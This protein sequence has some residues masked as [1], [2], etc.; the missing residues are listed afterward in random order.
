MTV[1]IV[2]VANQGSGGGTEPDELARRLEAHGA[3]VERFELESL[4]RIPSARPDRLVVA[5]GDGTVGP[6]AQ[7]ASKVGVPLAVIPTGTANDFARALE[8]PQDVDAACALA[9]RGARRQAI[10][11]ARLGERPFVNAAS[12]GLSPVAARSAGRL[13][14]SLGRFAY[15]FGALRAAAVATPVAVRV[16]CDGDQIFDGRAWQVLVSNTGAF[17]GGSEVGE[18]DP[19]DGLLDVTVIP[20]GGRARLLGD[21]IA[22][23]SGRIAVRPGVR[24]RRATELE[25]DLGAGTTWNVDGELVEAGSARFTVRRAAFELIVA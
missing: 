18:A 21:G 10:D 3:S 22:L 14:S 9:A 24:Q 4:N 15:A 12:A 8:L 2:L 16:S 20:A 1:R 23:R 17:G 19:S 11:L 6:A 25:L 5:G 7:A 13:K